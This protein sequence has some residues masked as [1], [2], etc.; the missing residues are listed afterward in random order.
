[1]L[2]IFWY[3]SFI[4]SFLRQSK[5]NLNLKFSGTFQNISRVYFNANMAAKFVCIEFIYCLTP[6]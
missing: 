5:T 6:V 4:C 2:I 1:M 3:L